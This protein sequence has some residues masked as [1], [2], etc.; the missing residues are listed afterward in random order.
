MPRNERSRGVTDRPTIRGGPRRGPWSVETSLGRVQG[1]SVETSLGRVQRT[2]N[3]SGSGSTNGKLLWVGFKVQRGRVQA[4][5]SAGLQGSCSGFTRTAPAKGTGRPGPPM[6]QALGRY[7][8]A[9][10]L[11]PPR[12]GQFVRGGARL[13]VRSAPP[14]AASG[15]SRGGGGLRPGYE[16]LPRST[17]RQSRRAAS[18]RDIRAR[19]LGRKGRGGSGG[20]WAGWVDC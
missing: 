16:V 4:R 14:E 7:F 6:V 18:L 15:R 1:R 10:G 20:R 8:H 19:D 5:A 3:F 12:G 13:P 9:L 11:V 2:E 17:G